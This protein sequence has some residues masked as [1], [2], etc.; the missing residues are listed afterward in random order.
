MTN[1]NP[2]QMILRA[3]PGTMI[4][5]AVQI[6]TAPREAA[7]FVR[8]EPSYISKLGPSPA[9]EIRVAAFAE[10]EAIAIA[11]MLKYSS[12]MLY[13]A[14]INAHDGAGGREA[15]DLL[16]TQPRIPIIWYALKRERQIEIPDR[17]QMTFANFASMCDH[18]LG[19]STPTRITPARENRGAIAAAT[20]ATL[21]TA[22]TVTKSASKKSASGSRLGSG[23]TH[24]SE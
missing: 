19:P 23:L 5:G 20:A 10:R 13:E 8:E 14:W 9:L 4:W 15:L 24:A 1:I 2:E 7:L 3:Q 17:M 18:C 21:P 6:N 11:I 16:A 12:D 22:G